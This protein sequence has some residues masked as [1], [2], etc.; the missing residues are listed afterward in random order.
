[1]NEQQLNMMRVI[2]DY[3]FLEIKEASEALD[4]ETVA[5]RIDE[6][7]ASMRNSGRLV[8]VSKGTERAANLDQAGNAGLSQVQ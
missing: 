1:M 8:D 3:L 5:E 7:A 2:R 6:L 4:F